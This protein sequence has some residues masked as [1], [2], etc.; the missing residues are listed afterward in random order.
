[1][2]QR[3]DALTAD[4][5]TA[6]EPAAI[7]SARPRRKTWRLVADAPAADAADVRD[8]HGARRGMI[9]LLVGGGLFWAAVAALVWVLHG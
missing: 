8:R 4:E 5:L 9:L 1:M 2:P 7:P 6:A 3:R